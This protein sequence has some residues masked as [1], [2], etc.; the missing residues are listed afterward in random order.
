MVAVLFLIFK[1]QMIKLEYS[2]ST[3]IENPCTESWHGFEEG[4]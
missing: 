4:A 3:A 1:C 2:H